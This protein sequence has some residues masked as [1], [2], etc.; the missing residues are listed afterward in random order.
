MNCY[1]RRSII[2]V[3]QSAKKYPNVLLKSPVFF[4]LSN[5]ENNWKRKYLFLRF[6]NAWNFPISK[7]QKR[8]Q[9]LNCH[10][11]K[12][13]LTKSSGAPKEKFACSNKNSLLF[14]HSYKI[15]LVILFEDLVKSSSTQLNDI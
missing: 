8:A 7:E 3:E 6:T 1:K 14:I 13:N 15:I 10:E 9:I 11:E 5:H 12:K 2:F 4:L